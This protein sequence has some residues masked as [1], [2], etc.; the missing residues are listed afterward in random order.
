MTIAERQPHAFLL[1]LSTWA[2]NCIPLVV[3]L[4][5][6]LYVLARILQQLSH[7][8]VTIYNLAREGKPL[9]SYIDIYFIIIP[10]FASVIYNSTPLST[11]L[12]TRLVS[13]ST[14]AWLSV[15]L[16]AHMFTTYAKST[17][18]MIQFGLT[19][20]TTRF[21]MFDPAWIKFILVLWESGLTWY[22]NGSYYLHLLNGVNVI[23]FLQSQRE[24]FARRG[25]NLT[26]HQYI[27]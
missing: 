21:L 19:Y 25:L 2:S 7:V 26:F 16:I 13:R 23:L 20:S 1:R 15:R 6:A 22:C 11:V 4:P 10:M 24:Y 27:P 18:T 9:P 8:G 14:P 5:V 17:S 3:H 12:N